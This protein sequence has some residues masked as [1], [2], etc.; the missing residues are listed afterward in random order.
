MK[1]PLGF[2]NCMSVCYWK[3]KVTGECN[4]KHEADP[5]E[6]LKARVQ[7]L[8]AQLKKYELPKGMPVAMR[9][10]FEDPP[11]VYCPKCNFTESGATTFKGRLYNPCDPGCCCTLMCPECKTV[12]A[13]AEDKSPAADYYRTLD[14]L[15]NDDGEK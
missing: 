10:H 6:V 13:L 1:C 9:E 2:N 15:E 3:H 8:E 5:V 4:H 11:Q 12:Y 14:D 7:E